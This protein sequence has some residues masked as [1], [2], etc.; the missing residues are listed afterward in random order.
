VAAK[1]RESLA[2]AAEI[3]PVAGMSALAV[4][5]PGVEAPALSAV[6]LGSPWPLVV[7][8]G[9]AVGTCLL[10]LALAR[11]A[12]KAEREAEAQL[13]AWAL[14]HTSVP[15]VGE[16]SLAAHVRRAWGRGPITELDLDERSA[17]ADAVFAVEDFDDLDP[18]WQE[19]ILATERRPR[20]RVPHPGPR[21]SPGDG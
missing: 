17:F 5:V 11:V 20:L 16:R 18:H 12:A 15:S 3:R 6:G 19:L 8:V 1:R 4:T 14:A 10:A 21:D 9:A 7:L 2:C 13:H